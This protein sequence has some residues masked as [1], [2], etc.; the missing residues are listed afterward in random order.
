M[1]RLTLKK[2]KES[3][4]RKKGSIQDDLTRAGEVARSD[5]RKRGTG[6]S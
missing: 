6:P 3:T 4:K 2:A 5:A 1:A